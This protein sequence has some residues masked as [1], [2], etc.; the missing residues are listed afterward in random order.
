MEKLIASE[1][2]ENRALD[3]ITQGSDFPLSYKK[4]LNEKLTEDIIKQREDRRKNCPIC[5]D[6]GVK[7]KTD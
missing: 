4:E 5:R 7:L 2:T 3:T 1:I 6:E